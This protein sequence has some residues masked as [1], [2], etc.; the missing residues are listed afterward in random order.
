MIV[1]VTS[2]EA[3]FVSVPMSVRECRGRVNLSG[4]ILK[5]MIIGVME[6]N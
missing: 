4:G 6:R 2:M 5:E 1:F 3:L